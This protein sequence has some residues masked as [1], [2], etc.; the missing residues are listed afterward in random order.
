VAIVV[1]GI[2]E[3]IA[4]PDTFPSVWLAFWWALQTVTTVGYGDVVPGKPA[5]EAG[6]DLLAARQDGD[7]TQPS[8]RRRSASGL[9]PTGLKPALPETI[10]V[11][12]DDFRVAVEFGDEGSLLH[13]GRSLRERKFEKELHQQLGDGVVI[14]RD[15]S[16]VFLYASTPEQARAAEKAVREVLEHLGVEADVSPVLRWHPV[17]E[18]WEDASVPLPQSADEVE[19]ERRRREEQDAKEAQELGYAEWEVRVDLPGHRDAVKLADQLEQE[20]IR[21]VV[22]RW[23]Y[24]LIG[25]AT[26]DD[27]RALAERIRAEAPQGADVKAEPSS[28][29][30][31]ETTGGNPFAPF[32]GFGPGP[33]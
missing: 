20:G 1:F 25:T 16:Q 10:P 21:P 33:T 3:R 6:P 28:T 31:W 15:G 14:S 24:L 4:D 5:G 9:W 2:V 29:I 30:G 11:M 23:K 12:A 8:R 26:E 19:T 27:A 17:E 7:R 18:R 13:F 32:G 22:R